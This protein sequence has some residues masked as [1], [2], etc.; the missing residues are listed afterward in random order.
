AGDELTYDLAVQ[1]N[2]P[3][4]ATDVTV[5]DTLPNSVTYQSATPSQ[6]SCV[7][8]GRRVTC[9]LG[10]VSSA[11]SATV[12]I[13]VTADND[14]TMTN[15]DS[16]DATEADP[17]TANNSASEQTTVLPTALPVDLA[18]T[19]TDSPDPVPADLTVTDRL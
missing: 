8:M 9:D 17:N 11:G 10:S 5:T 6:G 14:G 15:T 1:N 13:V 2:G 18:L 4:G 3:S 12:A 7:R 19:K 16:V